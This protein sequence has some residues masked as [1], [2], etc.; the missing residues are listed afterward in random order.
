MN[1]DEIL[2]EVPDY[3]EFLTVDELNVSSVDLVDEY[4]HI[5]LKNFLVS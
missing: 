2:R 1:L 3:K 5:E 4:N